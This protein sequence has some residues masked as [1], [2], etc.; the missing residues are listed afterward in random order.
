MDNNM[1]GF[2]VKFAKL[3]KERNNVTPS[4]VVLGDVISILPLKISILEGKVILTEE[5]CHLCG[6]VVK[7]I[8]RKADLS[9]KA[10][11]VNV[12]AT[13]S[14]GD[15]ISSMSVSEKTNYDVE[16]TYKD[17]LQI[18]DKVLCMPTV[19]GQIFFIID[20]VVL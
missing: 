20:R 12:S 3:L 7:D 16:I 10:Y 9:I 13:D 17:I 5:D 19:D 14:R 2:D 6:N 4:G 11:S 8:K 15:S 1:S 18:G